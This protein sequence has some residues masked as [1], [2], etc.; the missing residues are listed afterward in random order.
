MVLPGSAAPA[1]GVGTGT[2]VAGVLGTIGGVAVGWG[3]PATMGN[4]E[5][6]GDNVIPFPGT[7][8]GGICPVEPEDPCERL[9]KALDNMYTI[10]VSDFLSS[11]G[12]DIAMQSTRNKAR[13][14]DEYVDEYNASCLPRWPDYKRFNLKPGANPFIVE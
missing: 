12:N 3:W 2:G 7:N 5:L 6:P 1:T 9:R 8:K 14:F 4:G 11:S 13:I 10:L